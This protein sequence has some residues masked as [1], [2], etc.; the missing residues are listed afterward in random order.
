MVG[1][2]G[3]S[4]EDG[5]RERECIGRESS[6]MKMDFLWRAELD[7]Q[8]L[9]PGPARRVRGRQHVVVPLRPLQALDPQARLLQGPC[10]GIVLILAAVC[11]AGR[12]LLQ[13]P[14]NCTSKIPE[15]QTQVKG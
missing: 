9:E 1:G 3:N 2:D 15:A 5:E 10:P 12:R 11:F 4:T 8:Q 7:Q 14:D 6:E 13:T